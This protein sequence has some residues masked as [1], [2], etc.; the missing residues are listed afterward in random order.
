MGCQ[1]GDSAEK[2]K[3]NYRRLIK[4]NHPDRLLSQGASDEA[5]NQANKKVAE[6]KKAYERVM[7]AI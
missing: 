2:I 4:E 6:I 3:K 7:A 5:I 1:K